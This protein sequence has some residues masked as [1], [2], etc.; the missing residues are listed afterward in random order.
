MTRDCSGPDSAWT[1]AGNSRWTIRLMTLGENAAQ[2][3]VSRI[4]GSTVHSIR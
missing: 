1:S 4:A 2:A 3:S